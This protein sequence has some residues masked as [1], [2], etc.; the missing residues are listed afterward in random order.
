MGNSSVV[1]GGVGD[2][3]TQPQAAEWGT[4]RA[5]SLFKAERRL[6]ASSYLSDGY[7]KRIAI[8]SRSSGWK[9][10]DDMAKVWQPSRLKGVVV[11]PSVGKPFFA[12]GQVFEA[13]PV[14]R[15]YLAIEKTPDAAARFV[16]RGVILLSCSGSVGRTTIAYRLHEGHLITHDLLRIEP[17]NQ[18]WLGWI[19][20]FMRTPTFR[21]MATSAHYGHMIKHLEPE[22]VQRLPC[23]EVDRKTLVD[24]N[25]SFQDVLASRDKAAELTDAAHEAYAS[26]LGTDSTPIPMEPTFTT[27]AHELLKGRRRLDAYHHNTAVREVVSLMQRSSKHIDT[28]QTVTTGVWWPNRFRRVFGPNGTPYVSAGELFDVNAPITKNIYA[29]QVANAQDYFVEANWILMARSGQIYGLNGRVIL[30]SDRHTRFFVSEDIIRIV[31]DRKIIRPG[32]LEAVLSHPTL[33]RPVILSYA[34]GTSIPHLEPGDIWDLPIPR[35]KAKLESEI[36]AKIEEAAS[37]R[38]H[39]DDV[40]DAMENRAEQII[41]EYL[42]V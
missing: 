25:N 5:S 20:A 40:E 22:H 3:F 35:L 13:Q 32:Y 2:F 36:A 10:L 28:L 41:T 33:G 24:F 37:L 16:P 19:Y 31:P 34:Y 30:T 1:E 12:A 14:A 21:S 9:P 27:Y 15:K 8:E 18:N 29:G 42:H 6:E 26:A 7:G 23:V 38:A 11:D 39:A 17:R 4:V